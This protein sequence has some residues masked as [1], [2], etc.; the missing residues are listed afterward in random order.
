MSPNNWLNFLN[1]DFD[2]QPGAMPA[3]SSS[4]N[5]ARNVGNNDAMLSG[6]FDFSGLSNSPLSDDLKSQL[7]AWTN[8][9]FGGDEL[10]G[11]GR[12]LSTDS[13]SSYFGASAGEDSKKD[14][15]PYAKRPFG[16]FSSGRQ[17]LERGF[18]AFAAKEHTPNATI[19][20]SHNT[21]ASQQQQPIGQLTTNTPASTAATPSTASNDAPSW[22][23]SLP[24]FDFT[25]SFGPIDT[26]AYPMLPEFAHNLMQ[27]QMQTLQRQQ[28]LNNTDSRTSSV[29]NDNS[30]H[31][32][33]PAKRQRNNNGTSTANSASASPAA[34]AREGSEADSSSNKEGDSYIDSNGVLV[35]RQ[36]LLTKAAILAQ[37][38]EELKNKQ[39]RTPEEE[40]IRQA[41]LNRIAAEDDKRRRNTAASARFRVKKKQREAAL[42][43]TINELKGKVTLLEQELGKTKN[44]NSFLR[45]LVIRKIGLGDLST[46]GPSV[47][48]PAPS[49]IQSEAKGVGTLY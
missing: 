19:Q 25:K 29:S 45:D 9:S 6:G 3:P 40:A 26:A 27:Q 34:K 44:E 35:K 36:P 22:Q 47:S 46:S 39:G 42:E 41:E 8:V 37:Q 12:D 20:S 24:V 32:A 11:Q 18:D 31:A 16:N 49:I 38:L 10:N 7:E 5:N 14:P 33:P 28:A 15:S 21:P 43:D 23:S 30:S 1:L 2:A 48:V 17:A 13:Q 4:L